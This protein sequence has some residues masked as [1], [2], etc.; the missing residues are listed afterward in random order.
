MSRVRMTV[1]PNR[2]V[3]V[4]ECHYF[5]GEQVEVSET[6][7]REWS[8][9]GWANP[10][11]DTPTP[12]RRAPRGRRTAVSETIAGTPAEDDG[13]ASTAAST[14]TPTTGSTSTSTTARTPASR[15]AASRDTATLPP[16]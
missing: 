14:D 13:T 11:A 2:Q 7:A 1:A 8:R 16:S 3:V 5:G 6:T 9:Y 15:A 12:T 10:T 4:D